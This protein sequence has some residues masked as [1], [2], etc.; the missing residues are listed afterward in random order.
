MSL[1]IKQKVQKPKGY[2]FDSVVIGVN[3]NTVGQTRVCAQID[4]TEYRQKLDLW[5]A[6]G[7][8]S[9][10]DESMRLELYKMV[11]NC[12]GMIHIFAEDQLENRP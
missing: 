2:R 1:K 3:Q 5:F 6:N 7:W 4:A 12:D 9:V 8:I 10:N 11:S